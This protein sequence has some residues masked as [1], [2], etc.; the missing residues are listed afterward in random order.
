MVPPPAKPDGLPLSACFE[1]QEEKFNRVNFVPEHGY[2]A[3]GRRENYM[4][5]WQIGWTGGMI[6]TLPLLLLGNEA[7]RANVLRNFD[8]LFPAGISP[9]GLFW[10]SGRNGTE[11]IG[12]DLR[13]AH[14]GNWHLVRKSG[15]AVFYI[16]RQFRI[17]ETLGIAVKPSWRVGTHGVATALADL[18]ER[19]GQ[20]GQFIDALDGRV[21][22]GGSTSGGIVPA[23]LVHAAA[24]FED[25]RLLRVAA[26]SAEYFYQSFTTHGIACGGPGDALQNPDSES[27]YALVESYVAVWEATRDD[28]WLV[29]AGE[30]AR[31]LASWVVSYDFQFPPD[32]TFGR[33]DIRSTGAVYANT[34]NK[35]AAPGLCTASGLALLKLF[36]A[37]GDCFPAELLSDIARGLPQYLP[38][39]QHPL[40]DAEIGHICERVNLTDWEG[41]ARIGETHRQS[42]WAETSLMLTAAEIP[43]IYVRPDD[44]TLLVF[45]QIAAEIIHL[46]T[47]HLTIQIHNPNSVAASVRICIESRAQS[48]EPLP[49]SAL[50]QWPV[51]TLAPGETKNLHWNTPIS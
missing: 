49:D 30:A 16:V 28:K 47:D 14:T 3:V 6:S 41:K 13:K 25:D 23:A 31:Q 8:W 5:D 7:T 20:F 50:C 29:R 4:Q 10:D 39:P 26:E 43:G 40:G 17:M 36:R 51:E 33:A 48:L 27:A 32:S 15:D 38:S 18:W 46:E 34:Q 45:D 1:V 42:T 24:Y 22:V 12:G 2:Y 9:S 11:W 21:V 19:A 37:T 35:H 44:G